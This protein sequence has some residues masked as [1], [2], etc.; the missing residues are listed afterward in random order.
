MGKVLMNHLVILGQL[1]QPDS[2]CPLR[3]NLP[4]GVELDDRLRCL[5]ALPQLSS[6]R[7]VLS[8]QLPAN[9]W[10]KWGVQWLA[11]WDQQGVPLFTGAPS[12]AGQYFLRPLPQSETLVKIPS[13]PPS[14]LIS[15]LYYGLKLS[16]PT[17]VPIPSPPTHQV[18]LSIN[19]L[20]F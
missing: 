10:A 17:C 11:I 14:L 16:L 2:D 6:G 4:Q 15:D 7:C 18:L 19:V 20:H 5:Q 9:G 8:G 3:Q 13:F 12:C 1:R